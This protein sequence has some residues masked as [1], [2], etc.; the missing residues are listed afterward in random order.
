MNK[1]RMSVKDLITIGV[2]NTVAIVCYAVAILIACSTVIGLF[3]STA[4]AFLVMGTVYMLIACKV[5]KRGTFFICAALM[6]LV[7]LIGGRIF[8]TVGCITG[9]IIAEFIVGHYK[10]FRRMVLAYAGYAMAV[11]AGVY[12]PAFIIGSSYLLA[13]GAERGMTPEV[14]AQYDAYF[15]PQY[16]FAILVLNVIT[17]IIGACIGRL[18]LH[19]HFVKAGMLMEEKDYQ[20]FPWWKARLYSGL[21]F[22]RRRYQNPEKLLAEYIEPGIEIADIGSGMG[23]FTIPMAQMTGPQGR[24]VAV[25]LQKEMLQGLYRKAQKEHCEQQ[26]VL[27]GCSGTSLQLAGWKQHFSFVL[28]FAVAHETP[29]RNV[30]FSEI[31]ASMKEHGLLL[32][33]EPS[34][35][36]DAKCFEESVQYALQNGF[37]VLDYPEIKMSRATLLERVG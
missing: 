5:R 24:V 31:A 23:F 11:A 20:V 7:G 3:F 10:S 18:I 33:A 2:L 19:K 26:I 32:F 6:S 36:V 1:N 35:H 4:A 15:K 9:G 8:T 30:L 22:F 12:A 28:L 27:H 37:Q 16:F 34:G 13:R 17:A 14:V 25:D 21:L 29:D